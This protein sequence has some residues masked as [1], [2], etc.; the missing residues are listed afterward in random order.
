MTSRIEPALLAA[1]GAAQ[2]LALWQVHARWPEEQ[3]EPLLVAAIW[4]VVAS[5]LVLHLARTGARRLRLALLASAVGLAFGA[6]AWWVAA[7]LPATTS[8]AA[9]DASRVWTWSLASWVALFVLGPSLQIHQA[10]RRWRFPHAGLYRSSWRNLFV[11][12]LG[13]AVT[14][15]LRV[16]LAL[17]GAL[18]D[19]IGIEFFRQLFTEEPAFA[20]PAT[21][22]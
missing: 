14:A 4:A 15:V 10:T 12:V 2:G 18:F 1:L 3:V 9:G 16:V 13:G 19:L 7:Q 5:G 21:G 6:F 11:V 22:A 17:W 8:R 20:Y